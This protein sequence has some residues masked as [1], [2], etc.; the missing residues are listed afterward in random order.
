MKYYRID[1]IYDNGK[2]V[3]ITDDNPIGSFWQYQ[4]FAEEDHLAEFIDFN[5]G[6]YNYE[7]KLK[8]TI[9]VTELSEQEYAQV[10]QKDLNKFVN[11][12]YRNMH[13][14]AT[15]STEE[16]NSYMTDTQKFSKAVTSFLAEMHARNVLDYHLDLSKLTVEQYNACIR[17]LQM[18]KDEKEYYALVEDF[19]KLYK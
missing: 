18:T 5:L 13:D 4:C 9:Q 14:I 3:Y 16:Y 2:P 17:L 7:D 1:Y 12:R 15:M 19:K 10:F 11:E 8:F 6:R